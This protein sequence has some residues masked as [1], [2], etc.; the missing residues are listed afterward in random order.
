[1]KGALLKGGVLK[2]WGEVTDPTTGEK[3]FQSGP[4][5]FDWNASFTWD[6]PQYKVTWGAD[7]FGGFRESYYRFNLVEEFKV[8]TFVK[9]FIEYKP[10]PDLN[11]RLELANLTRR[12][13]HDI[14]Y[15]YPGLRAPGAH[16]SRI[17]DKNT[18]TI[19]SYFLRIRKTF[20]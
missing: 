15:I 18:N 11:I 14:F 13:I 3:R 5:R 17:D 10:R 4:H 6:M 9:P 2:R 7:V 19:D 20:G 16:V 1:M 12:N 8:N